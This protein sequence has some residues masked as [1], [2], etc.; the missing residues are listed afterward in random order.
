MLW[1]QS[2][3]R[4]DTHIY[5]PVRSVVCWECITS[6]EI[7]HTRYITCSSCCPQGDETRPPEPEPADSIPVQRDCWMDI[8]IIWIQPIRYTTLLFLHNYNSWKLDYELLQYLHHISHLQYIFVWTIIRVDKN[9]PQWAVLA[10]ECNTNI[11]KSKNN[12]WIDCISIILRC[13]SQY[14]RKDHNFC[15]TWK[16]QTQDIFICCVNVAI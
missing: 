4:I 9:I 8:L 1:K 12:Q 14:K 7:S 16:T 5:C 10:F 11:S 13:T 3:F 15:F 2:M 6:C